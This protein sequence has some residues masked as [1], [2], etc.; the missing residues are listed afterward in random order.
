MGRSIEIKYDICSG[1]IKVLYNG[2]TQFMQGLD[3]GDKTI[4]LRPTYID[5]DGNPLQKVGTITFGT[6]E[7]INLYRSTTDILKTDDNLDVADIKI[8]GLASPPH[9]DFRAAT[10]ETPYIVAYRTGGYIS[11]IR[12]RESDR[13]LRI[14]TETDVASQ[15]TERLRI[16]GGAATG[17]AGI[18]TP[19][20]IDMKSV[21][22][23]G[24][25]VL[26]SERLLQNITDIRFPSGCQYR[27]LYT[28]GSIIVQFNPDIHGYGDYL[29]FY[30]PD[31]AEYLSAGTW[32]SVSVPRTLFLGAK[33]GSWDIQYNWEAV[34]F[35]WTSFPYRW[36]EALYLYYVTRHHSMTVTVEKSTDGATWETLFTTQTLTGWPSHAVYV[37]Y[38]HN[39]G[40][41]YLRIVFTPTWDTAYPTENITLQNI[42]Y[43]GSYH[44]YDARKLFDWNAD[45]DITL[46][47][48]LTLPDANKLQWSDVNLYR[49]G[50]DQLATDDQFR[51]KWSGGWNQ[52]VFDVDVVDSMI[53]KRL[54]PAAH[55]WFWFDAYA[56]AGYQA[57]IGFFR[58]S[59]S[60]TPRF[61]ILRGDG[62]YNERLLFEPAADKLTIGGDVNLY[63]SAPDV[64]KTDDN[65]QIADGMRLRWSDVELYRDAANR[66]RLADYDDI[67]T[68]CSFLLRPH[69]FSYYTT[70][71]IM[72]E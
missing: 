6:L 8:R 28:Y 59:V 26:T 44:V 61:V 19:E 46:F 45:R 57:T 65:F 20:T 25:E 58:Y 51:I 50:A 3:I 10:G 53:A 69:I 17:A 13:S 42:R 27:S 63:R 7:D 39:S 30:P 2:L 34:R 70:E 66:L 5:M 55:N 12:F 64:L 16:Y 71:E 67:Y 37:H 18:Y 41:P 68:A 4:Y 9:I 29:R 72:L 11:G 1:D 32:Y 36:F 56:D 15:W 49:A 48:D 40:C 43:F 22:I 38:W 33:R 54:V 52:L 31:T 14:I 35:T 21:K 24:T 60:G 62:T 23:G 47:G